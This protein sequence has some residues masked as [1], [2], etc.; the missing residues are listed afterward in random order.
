MKL[1]RYCR[2]CRKWE[3]A[4][5]TAD[6]VRYHPGHPL[7]GDV[8]RLKSGH[9]IVVDYKDSLC[10]GVTYSDGEKVLS[11]RLY[12][13]TSLFEGSLEWQRAEL[14]SAFEDLPYPQGVDQRGWSDPEYVPD[15]AARDGSR[16]V[17]FLKSVLEKAETP[18]YGPVLRPSLTR[19]RSCASCTCCSETTST[20][21]PSRA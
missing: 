17:A 12:D 11:R 1:K 21:G 7:C 15:A 9:Y 2:L 5:H 3:H 14:V 10:T 4:A 6:S 13:Y 16:S 20:L 18:G 19:T 8:W